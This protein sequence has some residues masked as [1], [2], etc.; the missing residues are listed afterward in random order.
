MPLQLPAARKAVLPRFQAPINYM[1]LF[2]LALAPQAFSQPAGEELVK[3]HAVPA[4]SAV[5]PGDTL[6]VLLA[7]TITGGWHINSDKPLEEYIIPST[8]TLTDSSFELVETIW[9]KAQLKKFA[10]SADPM[11]VY[12]QKILVGLR[13]KIP[14]TAKEKS[15]LSLTG[16]FGYQAC[17]D[18]VCLPPKKVMFTTE[19]KT[20]D[21]GNK[22]RDDRFEKVFR[23]RSTTKQDGAR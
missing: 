1:L 11:A 15:T 16:Q 23:K 4:Q 18:E 10:F 7:V 9:P 3:I 5:Q 2:F 17:N 6:D 22:V 21:G 13:V 20:G 19:L 14:A 12:E 8:V